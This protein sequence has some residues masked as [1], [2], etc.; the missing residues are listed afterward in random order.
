MVTKGNGYTE[1]Q[2]SSPY[3][4]NNIEIR[5]KKS[6]NIPFLDFF[7]REFS[8]IQSPYNVLNLRN[9]FIFSLSLTTYFRRF[10]ISHGSNW[11]TYIFV[12]T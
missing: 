11:N 4:L 10:M 9:Q 12:F 2:S 1:K 8:E 7:I 5:N 3:S 6:K